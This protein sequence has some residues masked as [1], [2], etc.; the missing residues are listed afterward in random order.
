MTCDALNRLIMNCYD[1]EKLSACLGEIVH[2]RLTQT[3]PMDVS[4][5]RIATA[6]SRK[7]SVYI[8]CYYLQVSGCVGTLCVHERRPQIIPVQ[9][10]QGP[11]STW[12]M[13]R[14]KCSCFRINYI[15]LI[16]CCQIIRAVCKHRRASSR[17][18]S[19]SGRPEKNILLLSKKCL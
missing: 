13:C 16:D 18:S 14:M 7:T 15:F 4:T 1:V 11:L 2:P 12:A 10:Q 19:A 5:I 6:H 17:N 8:R 3:R 9:A